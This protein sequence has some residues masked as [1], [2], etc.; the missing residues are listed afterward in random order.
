M[1]ALTRSRLRTVLASGVALATAATVAVVALREA[2]EP[3]SSGS[4]PRFSC[5]HWL[6]FVSTRTGRKQIYARIQALI[7]EEAPSIFLYTQNDTLGI[8]RK[9]AYEA[10]ADEWLWLFAAKPQN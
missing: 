5:P 10:R 7:R 9:V 4:G 3:S 1:A 8:S 6:S 2:A